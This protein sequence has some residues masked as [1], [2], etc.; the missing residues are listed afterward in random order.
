MD[1]LSKYRPMTFGDMVGQDA[2]VAYLSAFAD[3]P[4]SAAFL[5][6]GPTGTGKTTAA[7]AL[8][9]ALGCAVDQQEL[10]G[11]H[12]IASGEQTGE[13]VRGKLKSLW[14]R[15][16][17]GTGSKVLIANECDEMTTSAAIVWLDALEHLPASTVVIFTTN[18]PSALPARFRDRC[19]EIEFRGNADNLPAARSLVS[20]IWQGEGRLEPAP[21]PTLDDLL[22]DGSISYRRAVNWAAKRLRA[23]PCDQAA[24]TQ[25]WW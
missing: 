22:D 9:R 7:Y 1:L 5:F 16:M 19:D 14:Q 8:A 24:T 12:E 23:T 10:G 21:V 11:L 20:R 13:S 2:A 17:F 15:P 4:Y 18:K 25:K 3:A 6:C